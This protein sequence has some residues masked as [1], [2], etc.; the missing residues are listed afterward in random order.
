[1]TETAARKAAAKRNRL[2]REAVQADGVALPRQRSEFI[3]AQRR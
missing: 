3:V 2:K 1:M